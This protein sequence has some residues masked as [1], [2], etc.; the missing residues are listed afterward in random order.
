MQ[1]FVAILGVGALGLGLILRDYDN[2]NVSTHTRS[3][4]SPELHEHKLDHK[5]QLFKKAT[6]TQAKK[7]CP[8]ANV[9]PIVDLADS[10]HKEVKT[11]IVHQLT[12]SQGVIT[13]TYS[14]LPSSVA[15]Q[16]ARK[17]AKYDGSTPWYENLPPPDFNIEI[18]HPEFKSLYA[19]QNKE[20]A[21]NNRMAAAT[22]RKWALGEIKVPRDK[23]AEALHEYNSIANRLRDEKKDY[24]RYYRSI[25]ARGQLQ[26]DRHW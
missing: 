14:Q 7:Q 23:Y 9:Q 5:V 1:F 13:G 19:A 10:A 4:D 6:K 8:P 11:N 16:R 21:P 12:H 17:P 24:D 25:S 22:F 18:E 3:K 15:N 20:V 26:A 2:A